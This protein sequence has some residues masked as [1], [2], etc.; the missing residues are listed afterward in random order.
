VNRFTD[1]ATCLRDGQK[2]YSTQG[3]LNLQAGKV[4]LGYADLHTAQASE[5]KWQCRMTVYIIGRTQ[6]RSGADGIFVT[7]RTPPP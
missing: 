3:A 7:K 4:L 1:S 2:P 6:A 5:P